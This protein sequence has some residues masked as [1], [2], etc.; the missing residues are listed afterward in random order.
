MDD[1]PPPLLFPGFE[2]AIPGVA[3]LAAIPADSV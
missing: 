3:M 2:V 1:N